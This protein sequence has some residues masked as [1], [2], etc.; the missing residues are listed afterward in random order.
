[1]FCV[2]N[3]GLYVCVYCS[4]FGDFTDI[5]AVTNLIATENCLN[6]TASWSPITGPCSDSVRYMITLSS[7]SNDTIGPFITSNTSYTFNNTVMLTGDVSVSVV[8]FNSYQ[9]GISLQAATQPSSISKN[10]IQCFFSTD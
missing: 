9:K 2:C 1:M 4:C 10:F 7:S 3:G 5:P 8:A 6:I